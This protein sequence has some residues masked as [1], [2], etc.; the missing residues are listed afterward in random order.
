[1]DGSAVFCGVLLLATAKTSL[2]LSMFGAAAGLPQHE[3]QR[4][5]NN[6][7][8]QKQGLRA[9]QLADARNGSHFA[10]SNSIQMSV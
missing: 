9:E 5:E 8:R 7:R 1:M 2:A 6:N 10:P 3:G 4:E